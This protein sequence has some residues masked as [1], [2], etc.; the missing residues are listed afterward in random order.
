[1]N[2]RI[3]RDPW[4]S[5][6]RLTR[7]VTT[8][9]PHYFA[10]VSRVKQ[11]V[12]AIGPEG[13]MVSSTVVPQVQAA[14]PQGALTKRIKVGL[15]A[16][17]IPPELTIKLLGN[18]VA[19]SPIVTVEP[20]RRKF[21]KPITLTLPLPQA[22]SKGMINHY[23]G[24]APTLR[25]L[26]SITGGTSRA[27]WEDVT[28]S[29]PLTFI[30]DCVSFTTTVSARFWLMDCRN[31]ADASKMATELYR[32]AIHV[33]FM[34]KFVVFAKRT[35]VNEARIRLFC[36]TDDREDK[37]LEYKEQFTEVS[38]SRDVEVLE[39]KPVYIEFAG[40]LVPVTKSGEQPKLV[41]RAF[42]ENRLPFTMRVKDPTAEPR[43]WTIIMKEPKVSKNEVS[44]T[45]VCVLQFALPE[46]IVPDTD[47][48]DDELYNFSYTHDSNLEPNKRTEL[49]ITDISNFVSDDWVSL[50]HELGF[51]S[52]EIAQIKKEYPESSSQQCMSMLNLWM[53]EIS[54]QDSVTVLESALSN[55]GRTDVV[56]KCNFAEIGHYQT[57]KPIHAESNQQHSYRPDDK[58]AAEEKVVIEDEIT[59]T[60]TERRIEIEQK[61][62]G[63]P[64]IIEKKSEP[65]VK[66]EQDT[67]TKTEELSAEPIEPTEVSFEHKR[68]SFERGVS[69]DQV[70]QEDIPVKEKPKSLEEKKMESIEEHGRD[71]DVDA[72]SLTFHE[73]RLSFEQGIP[74]KEI[75]QKK[76]EET[77][78]ENVA[79]CTNDPE[80]LSETE[81]SLTKS[82]TTSSVYENDDIIPDLKP[83]TTSGIDRSDQDKAEK[84]R[85]DSTLLEEVTQGLE[86][87]DA[88]GLNV[89]EKTA[90]L[91]PQSSK[92][93]PPSP[94]DFKDIQRKSSEEIVISKE[95]IEPTASWPQDN[96]DLLEVHGFGEHFNGIETPNLAKSKHPKS[97]ADIDDEFEDRSVV[98]HPIFDQ[99]KID[100]REQ[101]QI[102]K[103]LD[104][105]PAF[106]S[107]LTDKSISHVDTGISLTREYSD[108]LTSSGFK[109]KPKQDTPFDEEA[110]LTDSGL[111]PIQPDDV[112]LNANEISDIKKKID[113]YDAAN[114]PITFSESVSLS[115]FESE[116]IDV[117]TITETIRT[118]DVANSP[119]EYKCQRISGSK[120]YDLVEYT[121]STDT[122][123]KCTSQIGSQLLQ[124]VNIEKKML[125]NMNKIITP[126]NKNDETDFVVNLDKQIITQKNSDT[127]E[128]W[129]S[130]QMDIAA[131]KDET[132]V[133]KEVEE[134]ITKTIIDTGD[135]KIEDIKTSQSNK[136]T[137]KALKAIIDIEETEQ[138]EIHDRLMKTNKLITDLEV[139][140]TP[141]IEKIIV[142]KFIK[143]STVNE[144]SDEL[145]PSYIKF[146]SDNEY[147]TI[148]LLPENNKN[149]N[150]S[151]NTKGGLEYNSAKTASNPVSIFEDEDEEQESE[152]FEKFTKKH[153]KKTVD[154]ARVDDNR[155]KSEKDENQDENAV[156]VNKNE[157]ELKCTSV[158]E[159]SHKS[160]SKTIEKGL[161]DITK[162]LTSIVKTMDVKES[163]TKSKGKEKEKE[164]ESVD[165]D[166]K[167]SLHKENLSFEITETPFSK[168]S[169]DMGLS[170]SAGT[171][172]TYQ[173]KFKGLTHTPDNSLLSNEP[174]RS[175]NEKIEVQTPVDNISKKNN[176]IWVVNEG[177]QN[178]QKQTTNTTLKTK[179]TK[180]DYLTLHT[181]VA[182]I[183]KG[184]V[185][186]KDVR[187]GQKIYLEDY[188]KQDF[189]N[190]LTKNTCTTE[191]T[192]FNNSKI[193]NIE[194]TKQSD[195]K[196]LYVKKEETF[197]DIQ[198]HKIVKENKD[199]CTKENCSKSNTN[200]Q[201]IKTASLEKEVVEDESKSLEHFI[202]CDPKK[203]E[204]IP[205]NYST[206]TSNIHKTGTVTTITNNT[207]EIQNNVFK[208]VT[209]SLI[210][211]KTPT[212]S[213]EPTPDATN[214]TET[215]PKF[216]IYS[217]TKRTSELKTI[218][219]TTD[220][221][222]SE[223]SLSAT[224]SVVSTPDTKDTTETSSISDKLQDINMIPKITKKEDS[225]DKIASELSL[226]PTV[227]K[228]STPEA[229][230]ITETTPK[231][232]IYSD[233]KRTSELKTIKD[234]TDKVVSE[235][236]LSATVSVVST[237]DT[238]DTTETSSIS[239]KLQDI[240]MIPKITKK[241][242]SSDKIASELS[243]S[244]TVSKESTPEA[245]D[246]TETT[247]KFD[248]Y[249]DTKRTSELKTIK[250][251]TD[252]VVSEHS[253]SATV[254]VVST[255]DTKDTTETSSISDKLQD[256]NMIPKI[257]K[258]EDS[259]DK[260][261][262]EL[263]LSPTVVTGT[264]FISVKLQDFKIKNDI[265]EISEKHF[266]DDNT[267]DTMLIFDH[268]EVDNVQKVSTSITTENLLETKTSKAET[269]LEISKVLKPDDFIDNL[270]LQSPH[271]FSSSVLESIIDAQD[272][273]ETSLT[274]D[275]SQIIKITDGI[276]ETS[277]K[278]LDDDQSLNTKCSSQT[279]VLDNEQKL[280]TSIISLKSPFKTKTWVEEKPLEVTKMFSNVDLLDRRNEL[281]DVSLLP[282]GSVQT[283]HYTDELNKTL[284]T[285][286]LSSLTACSNTEYTDHICSTSL[287]NEVTINKPIQIIWE[288]SK[289]PGLR[290]G[291]TLLEDE[292]KLKDL[293]CKVSDDTV[294]DNTM[295]SE[296]SDDINVVDKSNAIFK[297]DVHSM[298]D[299]LYGSNYNSDSLVSSVGSLS[300]KLVSGQTYMEKNAVACRIESTPILSLSG[301]GKAS[302]K[303][304]SASFSSFSNTNT[305]SKSSSG[306]T[307]YPCPVTT[308]KINISKT[309]Y[310]KET[311]SYIKTKPV[312]DISGDLAKHKL[313]SSKHLPITASKVESITR[314]TEIKRPPLLSKQRHIISHG[315]KSLD[316]SKKLNVG[317]NKPVVDQSSITKIKNTEI[318]KE[319]SSF[320]SGTKVKLS[321]KLSDE[322][323]PKSIKSIDNTN[324]NTEKPITKTSNQTKTVNK[325]SS[326]L[327]GY[328]KIDSI[329]DNKSAVK[330]KQSAGA[331]KPEIE[332][333]MKTSNN[334]NLKFQQTILVTETA[335]KNKAKSY[336][337][338]TES[339]DRKLETS[340]QKS[341]H[342]YK[343]TTTVSSTR[344]SQI[345]TDKKSTVS[346]SSSRVSITKVQSK[347]PVKSSLPPLDTK[348]SV[349]SDSR[350]LSAPS[351]KTAFEFQLP[352]S[353]LNPLSLPGSPARSTNKANSQIRSVFITSEVFSSPSN[354]ASSVELVYEQPNRSPC[355]S[356]SEQQP[357][358][359]TESVSLEDVETTQSSNSDNE[360]VSEERKP[361]SPNLKMQSL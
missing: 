204:I 77:V 296:C 260:I 170:D 161:K 64:V 280:S 271:S 238:K 103:R 316:S 141:V 336:M 58:Y 19:V 277:E 325:K 22:A 273:T 184:I 320:E 61:I 328:S 145:D 123:T 70:L 212:V 242:D 219:D 134:I 251:T 344:S 159:K 142:P 35:D 174:D 112:G 167:K 86:K 187:D 306:P 218:K 78:S 157:N 281:S 149:S 319:K 41:V 93:P 146:S 308:D 252:I 168:D 32:E 314:N 54:A 230:D 183:P 67:S 151:D 62:T 52:N 355:S 118:I 259:S 324:V 261:A 354:R 226:S 264:S 340:N 265:K 256:I 148:Y 46:N 327:S 298:P 18:R 158:G 133:K 144:Q 209:E 139:N 279:K 125:E 321:T 231:F 351:R 37:T 6:N 140:K 43:S 68:M 203:R 79:E 8:E 12:H 177:N 7:I 274:S 104:D 59:K 249:S 258:K 289:S 192:P 225:S 257:T 49:R 1:M 290:S 120:I 326:P 83:E 163:S 210:E 302:L 36:M 233:T 300:S 156:M 178:E 31:V 332:K 89:E 128:I 283:I 138:N 65:P 122:S 358:S 130:I 293:E 267:N 202:L 286:D 87:L 113:M 185:R 137:I 262:S 27:Q 292:N 3:D 323:K 228:E 106:D 350:V 348:S 303:H 5:G 20:R 352:S 98:I 132:E 247:P 60:V 75:I 162:T 114:S 211:T 80:C 111:S 241:E 115:P 26:C 330:M 235:H 208:S 356:M 299:S 171:K 51:Q 74:V 307:T 240:N 341:I 215:T 361:T 147:N 309:K 188:L 223:H 166:I 357:A 153:L 136:K 150:K 342:S 53:N 181:T 250:D 25:L 76:T 101:L 282:T 30:N 160:V 360:R 205:D 245:T 40:N 239:D 335:P 312:S 17:P 176:I 179:P 276:K 227:S 105:S 313:S 266:N 197:V 217:D 243:L 57:Q 55:I 287:N 353:K 199:E 334:E 263:S 173:N 135:K 33:P 244:P 284:L 338:S 131:P 186:H 84:K 110:E 220:K 129:K 214:I 232:D 198:T 143:T 278:H 44:Q 333:L 254:S 11:E 72:T 180:T 126:D 216:D 165:Y 337:A 45:P 108:T 81:K 155:G 196:E 295:K 237:P 359:I 28:G 191:Q 182:N 9:F 88:S 66:K 47:I 236:S 71:V 288:V 117:A 322:L 152:I 23:T 305:S 50:A 92:T 234:T 221:V 127:P 24:D 94:A 29:T 96:D 97:L 85:R 56:E 346:K 315:S 275:K 294:Y 14:F 95:V 102:N 107:P 285:N 90:L 175:M 345:V 193:I 206:K 246:I 347:I 270:T 38:N 301:T 349:V 311:R 317:L 318:K 15:Q 13:G 222:V 190:E 189:K 69:I 213:K 195:K 16:Q 116:T 10:I 269:L 154:L 331:S 48:N 124:I 297:S 248:I 21:H 268:K 229:T 99:L 39:G 121:V 253:L 329:R 100:P 310:K 63:E 201:L 82:E 91:T 119:I 255:P 42:K 339:R 164:K 304:D 194:L 224:V 169:L 2:H 109:T 272:L 207:I 73:K 343:M 200:K 34:A 291:I 172:T 4:H